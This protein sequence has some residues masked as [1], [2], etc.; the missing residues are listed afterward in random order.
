MNFLKELLFLQSWY[1]RLA[2]PPAKNYPPGC[3]ATAI[4]TCKELGRDDLAEQV[5]KVW[6]ECFQK[7]STEIFKY[8][9]RGD[10]YMFATATNI[11]ARSLN[12]NLFGGPTPSAEKG[13][14]AKNFGW[15]LDKQLGDKKAPALPPMP[16]PL[17][18]A[19]AIA[20][21][22]ANEDIDDWAA[23]AKKT[24]ESLQAL[25]AAFADTEDF[26]QVLEK[27]IGEIGRKIADYGPG[28][29]KEVTKSGKPHKLSLRVPKWQ[30][31][32][33]VYK[34]KLAE[35]KSGVSSAKT[36]M[37]SAEAAYR[38]SPAVTVAY[39]K[40]AQQSLEG[41]LE[42][43][44]DMKDLK[45]QK[46][47]LAKFNEM[48]KNME[49]EDKKVASMERSAAFWDT[50]FNAFDSVVSFFSSAWKGLVKWT[51]SLFGAVDK[52]DKV[53]TELGRY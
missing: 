18:S 45:K 12:K 42:V 23:Q 29:S 36:K 46:E 19:P 33:E 43:I 47:M 40:E 44:M 52:F 30:I 21:P 2:A 17:D 5:E 1:N 8:R 41:V 13:S 11:A 48:V 14:F 10:G 38:K 15:W 27:E 49:K 37:E 6:G 50:I 34:A 7:H 31:E 24:Q 53:A 16:D 25:Q 3:V 51:K 35:T 28:G 39:E 20:L 22:K 4:R 32:L 26:I 9:D